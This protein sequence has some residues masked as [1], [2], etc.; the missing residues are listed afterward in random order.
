MPA[1]Y[2]GSLPFG[3]ATLGLVRAYPRLLGLPDVPIVAK[4]G[5]HEGILTFT[6]PPDETLPARAK[7]VMREHLEEVFFDGSTFLRNDLSLDFIDAALQLRT[8][9]TGERLA[10][11]TQVEDLAR[12]FGA[13][14]RE[15][16]GATRVSLWGRARRDQPLQP[17]GAR[18]MGCEALTVCPLLVGNREVGRVEMDVG[19]GE[20]AGL[21]ELEQILPWLALGLSHCLASAPAGPGELH[22][23]TRQV[24]LATR[25]WTLTPR[26][27]R[28]LD[29]VLVGRSNKEIAHALDC[30]VKNVEAALTLM[31]RK[32]RVGSRTELVHGVWSGGE[33]H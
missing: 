5:P 12:D 7:R 10:A 33:G 17:L 27:A 24:A 9:A 22:A 4:L 13:E 11:H 15:R 21:R 2:R 23:P 20:D 14:A 30:S 28:V 32:A 1:R 29:L 26:E 8:T 16:F 25:R 31:M 18:E 3:H 6:L 19:V